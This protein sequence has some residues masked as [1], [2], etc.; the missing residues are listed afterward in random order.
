MPSPSKYHIQADKVYADIVSRRD[1]LSAVYDDAGVCWS[2]TK[3]GRAVRV[4]VVEILFQ[5]G[6]LV[7]FGAQ[8]DPL[9]K[10]HCLIPNNFDQKTDCGADSVQACDKRGFCR[11]CCPRGRAREL[12]D[13]TQWNGAPL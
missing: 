5:S 7:P 13:A 6:K 2:M 9:T 4:E 10:P 1:S 12:A 3:T 8:I 11:S